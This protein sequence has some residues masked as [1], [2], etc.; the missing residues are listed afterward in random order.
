ME[1]EADFDA[2]GSQEE[3]RGI[4]PMYGSQPQPKSLAAGDDSEDDDDEAFTTKSFSDIVHGTYGLGRYVVKLLDTPQFQRTRRLKQLGLSHYVFPSA[5]H[6]RFE[7]S[8]GVGHLAH[9]VADRIFRTQ[10]HELGIT[11]HDVHL[12]SIA[13]S[14]AF[15]PSAT[16]INAEALAAG[17][18]V[19]HA[20]L[21][22]NPALPA[23]AASDMP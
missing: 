21:W 22:G 11:R 9:E 4:D 20:P 18:W 1:D 15:L 17:P 12:V 7:H 13:G 2:P 10:G 23:R 3:F 16:V 8:L 5:A 14:L 19:R 6:T